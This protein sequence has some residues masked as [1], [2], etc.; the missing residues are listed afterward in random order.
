MGLRLWAVKRR[1]TQG[2]CEKVAIH[3]RGM[4]G[5]DM[6]GQRMEAW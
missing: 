6:A 3:H 1:T 5:N 2:R 4:H